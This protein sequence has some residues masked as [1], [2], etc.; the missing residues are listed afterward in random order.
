MIVGVT[1]EVAPL[2]GLV[3]SPH[4]PPVGMDLTWV[5]RKGLAKRPAERFQ[6]A[7]EMLDRL[8]RR[9]E[10]KIPVQCHITLMKRLTGEWSRF[11]DRHPVVVTLGMAGALIAFVASVVLLVGHR[12]G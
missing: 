11:V 1:T 2:V 9:A 4:Q 12:L 8:S 10:G 3:H 7:A 6:S 5:V